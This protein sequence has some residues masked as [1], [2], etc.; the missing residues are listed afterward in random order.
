MSEHI[1]QPKS[2][3]KIFGALMLLTAITV[4]VAFINFGPLN[5]FIAMGIAV[6]KATLVILFFMH[7]RYGTRLTQVVVV[8]GFFWLAI[9]FVLIGSDY[10]SRGYVRRD[11]LVQPVA[12]ESST[13]IPE[14]PH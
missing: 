7:V 13:H 4:G 5:N 1:V 10:L 12:I 14:T 8:A 2:Y 9:M 6:T 3:Y 11:T